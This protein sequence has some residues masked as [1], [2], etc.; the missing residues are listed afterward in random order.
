MC[1]VWIIIIP[2]TSHSIAWTAPPLETQQISEQRPFC[3]DLNEKTFELLKNFLEKYTTSFYNN[4]PPSPFQT[5]AQHYRFVLHCLKLLSTHLNLCVMKGLS[6]KIL[7]AQAKGLRILL[8][9]LVDVSAPA[10][11]QIAIREILNLGASLLLPDLR[12]RIE[13]LCEQLPQSQHL[14]QGQQMLLDVVLSS[15]E[16]PSHVAAILGYGGTD[17]NVTMSSIELLMTTLLET[18]KSHTVSIIESS[19]LIR[20]VLIG[21]IYILFDFEIHIIIIVEGRIRN[22]TSI[23]IIRLQIFMHCICIYA[24]KYIRKE[25]KYALIHA[26]LII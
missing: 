10:D 23:F 26:F 14:S 17:H 8:F 13:L 9:N 19:V 6:N 24:C 5:H 21:K 4:E 16:N 12:E 15:L 2:G 18:F 1:L 7:G 22:S 20:D 25:K 3:L 11:I